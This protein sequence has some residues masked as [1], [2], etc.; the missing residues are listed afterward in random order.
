MVSRGIRVDRCG[1]L[2][3]PLRM[4]ASTVAD[5]CVDRCGC[6]RRPMRMVKYAEG[7]GKKGAWEVCGRCVRG[8]GGVREKGV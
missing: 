6:L 2:R 4:S 5:V 1:C 7:V 3:R 8:A